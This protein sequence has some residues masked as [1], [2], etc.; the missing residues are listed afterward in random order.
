M[1]K[2]LPIERIP[3]FDFLKKKL[4]RKTYLSKE[5][6]EELFNGTVYITEKI[7]GKCEYDPE[8]G[9][10]YE[11]VKFKHTIHYTKLPKE[12]VD[13]DFKVCLAD[14]SNS[15]GDLIF[16]SEPTP[17]SMFRGYIANK[18]LI[19]PLLTLCLAQ[20]SAWSDDKVEGIVVA[21]Y[22]KQIFGK[23][24]R[25]DFSGEIEENWSKKQKILN[26]SE[27]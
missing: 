17:P 11:N 5:K 8:T 2:K 9:R 13:N 1:T 6:L 26:H 20:K 3:F 22:E 19:M 10:Y 23:I 14:T 21:N 27:K 18:D 7:D 12:I 4:D 25:F 15:T 16:P 24:S